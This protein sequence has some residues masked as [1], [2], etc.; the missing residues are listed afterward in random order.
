MNII[1]CKGHFMGPISGADELIVN[2]TVQLKKAGHNPSVL[3]L[4]R[5]LDSD[6]YLLRLQRAGIPVRWITSSV[7]VNSIDIYCKIARRLMGA[8]PAARPLIRK[9]A[10]NL[11]LSQ[12]SRHIDA[13]RIYFEKYQPDIVHVV[14]PNASAMIMIRA[15]SEAGIPVLYQELGIPFHP[16]GYEAQYEQFTSV[17][18]A[19]SE[20]AALS[21]LLKLMCYEKLHSLNSLSIF[22]LLIEDA[23]KQIPLAE[24]SDQIT[25]GFA[26]RFEHMKGPLILLRA[27]ARV[28]RELP[29]VRLKMAGVGSQ[30]KRCTSEAKRLGI[31]S[32]VTFT[33]LYTDVAQRCRFMKGIDVF[34]L[35]SLSEGT[36]TAVVEAMAHG[37]TAIVTNVGG[38]PDM[39]TADEGIVIPPEDSG[40]L[41]EAMIQ[42]ALNHERR[43][44]MSRAASARYERLFSRRAVLP[45]MVNNYRR[46]VANH[47]A[48]GS[49]VQLN[50]Q[51][52][53][54]P[55]EM[56]YQSELMT[57]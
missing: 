53:T 46:I 16:P 48:G 36:P 38:V 37:K 55:W 49:G 21:P 45:V 40:A 1:F 30:L 47:H 43:W 9:N 13:C 12:A 24:S 50:N 33:G 11:T 23:C 19:C 57:K 5:P 44:Q 34:V 18:S 42:L 52:P 29:N 27:F 32:S 26:A 14:T 41:V 39:I 20:V 4:Y 54:H 7:I 17:L 31:E 3:L 51:I 8:F 6:Q 56:S 22:P 15:A 28:L 35:P 25:F 10:H 2:N